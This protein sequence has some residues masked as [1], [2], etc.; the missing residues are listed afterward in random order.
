[1]VIELMH[2]WIRQGIPERV[3]G[4]MYYRIHVDCSFTIGRIV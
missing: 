3:N 4:K 1:M 2:R